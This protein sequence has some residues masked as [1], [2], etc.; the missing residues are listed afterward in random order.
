MY[1]SFA[2]VYQMQ[3]NTESHETLESAVKTALENN[4]NY[5]SDGYNGI[6]YVR[7]LTENTIAQIGNGKFHNLVEAGQATKQ[8]WRETPVITKS[9]IQAVIDNLKW[10]QE[11][12]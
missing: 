3:H 4:Y 7:C 11:R 12:K 9:I 5:Y 8:G 2:F 6:T 10:K 1:Q